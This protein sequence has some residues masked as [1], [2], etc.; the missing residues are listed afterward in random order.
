VVDLHRRTQRPQTLTLGDSQ[1]FY[2]QY[3]DEI[4]GQAST[5]GGNPLLTAFQARL[6]LMLLKFAGCYHTA[7]SDAEGISTAALSRARA[8]V[9]HLFAS[10]AHLLATKWAADPQDAKIQKVRTCSARARYYHSRLQRNNHHR[11]DLN[12]VLSPPPRR[13]ALPILGA[14][15][16]GTLLHLEAAGGT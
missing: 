13:R 15:P 9:D 11:R 4:E 6:P 14:R 12:R 5:P 7:E 3:E 8:L 2:E 10:F 16:E 1:A